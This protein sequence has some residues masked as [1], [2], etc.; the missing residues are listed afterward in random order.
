MAEE[1]EVIRMVEVIE[2]VIET[3]DKLNVT[4]YGLRFLISGN[5][6]FFKTVEDISCDHDSISKLC[7]VIQSSDLDPIHI[8]NVIEDFI[9][10]EL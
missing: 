5:D 2:T 7:S 1:K 9:S 3:E 4:T 8:D 10:T 6:D